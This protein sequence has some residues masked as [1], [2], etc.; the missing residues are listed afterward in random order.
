[1]FHR[2]PHTGFLILANHIVIHGHLGE[3]VAWVLGQ[4][5]RKPRPMLVAKIPSSSPVAIHPFLFINEP[6]LPS[7]FKLDTG[8]T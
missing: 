8:S 3:M 2:N 6:S 7:I 1:M 4:G 5:I